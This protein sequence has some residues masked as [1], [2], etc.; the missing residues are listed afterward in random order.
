[1]RRNL[2][3]VSSYSR[4]QIYNVSKFFLKQIASFNHACTSFILRAGF[5]IYANDD[6]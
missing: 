3:F 2:F 4:I 5:F 1:M 6:F